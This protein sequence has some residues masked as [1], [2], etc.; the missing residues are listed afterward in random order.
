MKSFLK[1][2]IMVWGLASIMLAS[3]SDSFL[4]VSS[5]TDSNT[6]N[7]YKTVDDAE[8]ALIGCYNGWKRTNSDDVRSFYL[9]SELMSDDCFAGT[10]VTD[11][12]NYQIID[13]FDLSRY[14]AGTSLLETVWDSYYK[15]I[16]RC[17]ELIKYDNQGQIDWKDDA[18]VQ[19]RVIGECRMIRA[20]C[21]FDMVRLWE[22]IPL[23]T[24]PTDENVPQADPNDV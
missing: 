5:K 24:E 9:C 23:L 17:N 22:N 19:G 1:S 21:Y 18:N 15:A 16:Y 11:A 3:C 6:G 12:P 2:N 8:L 14:S 10:G 13:R 4:D 7:F 20:L